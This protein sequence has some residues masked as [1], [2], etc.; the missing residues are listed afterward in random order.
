MTILLAALLILGAGACT[1]D[2]KS[3]GTS[4][5]Q[6]LQQP[7]LTSAP[8]EGSKGTEEPKA[9]EEPKTEFKTMGDVW[10]FDPPGY[11]CE[12][13]R[14][15]R[16]FVMDGLFCRADTALTD[17]Q[18]RQLMDIDIFDSEAEQKA[19]TLISELPIERLYVLSDVLLSQTELD[20]LV[21]RTGQE[22]L[23]T[24][25]EYG[26]GYSFRDTAR[27]YMNNSCF[28]TPCT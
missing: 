22:L 18:F 27:F 6:T 3:A 24:G 14:Y 23:D 15:I 13:N 11:G 25:F 4:P 21:G 2:P 7:A 17:E 20:A 26:S 9:T 5:V 8:E 1:K 10:D 28:R 19:K 16:L 12:N